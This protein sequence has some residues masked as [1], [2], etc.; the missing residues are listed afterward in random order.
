MVVTQEEVSSGRHERDGVW[1]AIK[2]GRCRL[3]TAL[4]RWTRV[5]VR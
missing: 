4:P 5:S 3:P 1:V 2:A